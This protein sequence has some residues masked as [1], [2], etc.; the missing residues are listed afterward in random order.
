MGNKVVSF[1]ITIAC[2]LFVIVLFVE[3]TKFIFEMAP[4]LRGE[5]DTKQFVITSLKDGSPIVVRKDDPNVGEKVRIS[6]TVRSKF[7]DI[8]SSFYDNNLV[9]IEV[10]PNFGYNTIPLA[11]GLKP[12]GKL[13]AFEANYRV[14]T[15]LRKSLV[16]NDI[17][18]K[19][20]ARN[21]AI[22][23]HKGACD[24]PDCMSI[25]A[26]EDGTYTSPRIFSTKCTT[27]DEELLDEDRPVDLIAIDIPNMEIP[28]L[29]SCETIIDR[30]P[31]IIIIMTF[32]NNPV[33]AEARDVLKRLEQKGIKFYIANG[34]DDYSQVTIEAL[35]LHRG[36]VVMMTRKEVVEI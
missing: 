4:K 20:E 19:V 23:D 30:S 28:I 3:K 15:A 31:N 33:N 22:S 35:L 8:I 27:L 25:V 1:A 12:S 16:L 29:K 11:K 32:E 34:K 36:D 24:I 9:V 14:W 7:N 17:D 5:V 6:G 26:R 21:I 10:G 18:G 2:V 13:Y